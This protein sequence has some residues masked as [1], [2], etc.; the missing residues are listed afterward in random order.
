MSHNKYAITRDKGEGKNCKEM[1][2]EWT[3]KGE[4]GETKPVKSR[5]ERN[6]SAYTRGLKGI[7]AYVL[8]MMLTQNI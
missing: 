3:T 8:C 6:E 5:C 1:A 7:M 2:L 4:K